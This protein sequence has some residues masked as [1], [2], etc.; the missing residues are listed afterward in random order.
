ML[1]SSLHMIMISVDIE[2]Y[3]SLM[4]DLWLMPRWLSKSQP[5]AVAREILVSF[6]RP[7]NYMP[8]LF[9]KESLAWFWPANWHS[10]SRILETLLLDHATLAQHYAV[11]KEIFVSFF[12]PPS[13]VSELLMK[14]PLHCFAW[15]SPANI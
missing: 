4:A 13:Y 8:E 5:N 1:Y 9:M 10:S 3:A 2:I 14:G 7:P 6:F 12:P 11:A 15:F